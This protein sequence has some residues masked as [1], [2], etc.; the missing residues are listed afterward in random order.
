M[1]FLKYRSMGENL[2]FIP[3]NMYLNMHGVNLP[4]KPTDS[5]KDTRAILSIPYKLRQHTP[6][7]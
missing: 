6:F 4:P 7:Y 3:C 2:D 1:K 5:R